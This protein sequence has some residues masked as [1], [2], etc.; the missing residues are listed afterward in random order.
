MLESTITMGCK[1][2]NIRA[3]EKS[4]QQDI[5]DLCERCSDFSELIEGRPLEKDAGHHI[6]FDLPGG[7]ALKD[8]YVYGMYSENGILI[9]VIDTIKNFPVT[10]EWTIGLLMI[11]PK[12]RGKGFGRK[13][14]ALLSTWI[15]KEQGTRLRI[16]VIEEN[17]K[18]AAFWRQMGYTEVKRVKGTYGNKEHM[19]IVMDLPLS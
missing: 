14:H 15:L 5:Q 10:G 7:K 6:L 4:H 9:A 11:D 12:E 3:L 17:L 19:V 2:Y 16:G 18:G 8:K 1:I 13:L